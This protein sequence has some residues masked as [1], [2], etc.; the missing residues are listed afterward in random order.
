MRVQYA[1]IVTRDE[2]SFCLSPR[3]EAFF[4]WRWL[5]IEQPE[6]VLKKDARQKSGFVYI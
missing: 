2:K 4:V 5:K 1:A 3:V 6:T